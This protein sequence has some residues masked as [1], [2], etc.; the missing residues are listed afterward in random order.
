[1]HG[2]LRN[3]N[4]DVIFYSISTLKSAA[5]PVSHSALTSR[6]INPKQ[7]NGRPCTRSTCYAIYAQG[8]RSMYLVQMAADT[9]Y[10]FSLYVLPYSSATTQNMEA[11]SENGQCD[12]CETKAST[13][14]PCRLRRR[15]TVD[16][17]PPRSEKLQTERRRD[18]L[19]YRPDWCHDISASCTSGREPTR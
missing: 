12:P 15:S 4:D 16:F 7:F 10:L 8:G 18:F 14:D 3:S 1:M 19:S 2:A 5:I 9:S 13:Q 17:Q 6:R 11:P